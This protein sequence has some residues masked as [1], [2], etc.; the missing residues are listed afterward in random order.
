MIRGEI[1]KQEIEHSTCLRIFDENFLKKA[2]FQK[3]FFFFLLINIIHIAK[4]RR[5]K[6]LQFFAQCYSLKLQF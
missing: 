3:D 2:I 6:L 1:E 5:E 4:S